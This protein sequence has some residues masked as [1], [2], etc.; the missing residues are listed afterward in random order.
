MGSG[1]LGL[2]GVCGLGLWILCLV[3][4]LIKEKSEFGFFLKGLVNRGL[5]VSKYGT[6]V[7][8]GTPIG[9]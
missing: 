6:V 5:L 1:G 3:F 2:V 8:A 9:M 4:D 7:V